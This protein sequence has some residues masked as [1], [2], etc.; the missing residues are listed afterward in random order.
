MSRL[1]GCC[2][3]LTS[4]LSVCYWIFS[5][6]APLCLICDPQKYHVPLF[7]WNTHPI[8]QLPS[9]F[10]ATE[11]CCSAID[12]VCVHLE[13]LLLILDHISNVITLTFH[14]VLQRAGCIFQLSW[15]TNS[16]NWLFLPWVK[17]LLKILTSAWAH[18]RSQSSHIKYNPV[19][20]WITNIHSWGAILQL[21][22][23]QFGVISSRLCFHTLK[24][25]TSTKQ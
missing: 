8:N 12:L 22:C 6:T 19:R 24:I 4:I 21:V 2:Y 5:G 20:Q 13:H 17:S 14:P 15:L 11:Y 18:S 1:D 10:C 23:A 7:L 16:V 3:Y 9:H 25:K